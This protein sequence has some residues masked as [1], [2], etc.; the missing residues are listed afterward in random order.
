MMYSDPKSEQNWTS[1][2]LG[3][4]YTWVFRSHPILS[5]SN[6]YISWSSTARCSCIFYDKSNELIRSKI[7]AGLKELLIFLSMFFIMVWLCKWYWNPDCDSQ[8]L[9]SWKYIHLHISIKRK[10]LHSSELKSE[11]KCKSWPQKGHE[12][13]FFPSAKRFEQKLHKSKTRAHTNMKL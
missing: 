10:L 11:Q 8:V 12:S 9:M 5:H 13:F 6:T 7:R 4:N 2:T 3:W 1:W